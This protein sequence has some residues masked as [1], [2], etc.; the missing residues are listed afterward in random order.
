MPVG[1][2]RRVGRVEAIGREA[3]FPRRSP[4]DGR[5]DRWPPTAPTQNGI[6]ERRQLVRKS[7]VVVRTDRCLEEPIA[8]LGL[9]CVDLLGRNVGEIEAAGLH[10][11]V[12]RL[13]R[14]EE[15]EVDGVGDTWCAVV[16]VIAD[17]R[18]QH[19][20]LPGAGHLVG[21]VADREVV[22]SGRIVH[23]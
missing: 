17:E 2:T 21:T 8:E 19:V 12:H 9:G 4:G 13:D 20:V 16:V 11:E 6:V 5:P 7:E 22:V 23:R 15:Q 18:D 10:L 3:E 14:V 1:T